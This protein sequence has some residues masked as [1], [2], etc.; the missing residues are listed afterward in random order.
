MDKHGIG[1]TAPVRSPGI[2]ERHSPIIGAAVMIIDPAGA[3]IDSHIADMQAVI[4]KIF[5]DDIT[6]VTETNNEV[7]DAIRGIALRSP[8]W[9]SALYLSPLKDGYRDRP[10]GSLLSS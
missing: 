10:P 6:L 4:E 2:D 5:F 9:A 3:D 1:D 7:L 8:P